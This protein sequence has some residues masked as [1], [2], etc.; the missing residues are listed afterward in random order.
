M[1]IATVRLLISS[2]PSRVTTI[3]CRDASIVRRPEARI[4]HGNPHDSSVLFELAE[5]TR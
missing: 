5:P 3:P 1:R 2:T 4:L